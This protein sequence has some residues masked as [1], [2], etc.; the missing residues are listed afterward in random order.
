MC[1]F[2]RDEADGA[3]GALGK[4]V[5]ED[6]GGIEYVGRALQ[7]ARGEVPVPADMAEAAAVLR[8]AAVLRG[9]VLEAAV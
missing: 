3:T 7:F 9:E 4:S 5:R 2:C 1:Y 6:L 8:R